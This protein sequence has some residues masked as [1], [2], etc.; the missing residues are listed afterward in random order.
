MKQE[1]LIKAGRYF[2]YLYLAGICAFWW[3]DNF[4]AGHINWLMTAL[5][6]ICITAMLARKNTIDK[7]LGYYMALGSC[8]MIAAVISACVRNSAKGFHHEA[9]NIIVFGLLL[10]ILTMASSVSLILYGRRASQSAS[11]ASLEI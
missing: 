9:T 7:Y 6:A 5:F 4:M 10:F 11:P 3:F 2:A 8:Y 1:K